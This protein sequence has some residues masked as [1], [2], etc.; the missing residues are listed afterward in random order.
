M[1]IVCAMAGA[2]L[3]VL[4]LRVSAQTITTEAPELATLI[5]SIFG[6]RGLTVHSDALLPDG[7]THSAHFNSAFQ[8]NFRQF[9]I[10]LASQLTSVP[11]P[12]PAS[13]FTYQFDQS[14][15]TFVRSTQS[16]GP[17]LA[18]RAETIGAGKILFGYN[19]Q[20]FSF[21]SLEGVSLRR[22][23][24]VFTHDDF[25]LGGGRADVV[26]T[27]NAIDASVSQFTG[28]VT[29]GLSD[30][31]DVS[32]A[33]PIVSTRL[34]VVSDAVIHRFGTEAGSAVHFFPEDT[35]P[36]GFGDTQQFLSQG[37]AAGVGDLVLRAKGTLVREGN[38]GFAAGLEIRVPSGD[39]HDLLGSGAWGAKPFAVMS[40]AVKKISPH[41]N[42]GYQWN[43]SSVLAGD[44]KNGIKED[45]PDRIT[46]AA[47]ADIGVNER[48]TLALDFL[49]DRIVG[50]PRLVTQPFAAAGPLGSGT[51]TDLTFVEGS[52]F[53][54]N[55]S[56]GIKVNVAP[57]MLV[58]FNVRFSTSK[59]GLTDRVAPLL[60][61]EYGF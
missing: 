28:L 26:V 43:G 4:P 49:A 5:Q 33:V 46:V 50:S 61:I 7:S 48:L 27:T 21:D 44:P 60:G 12:S 58:N 38:R 11:L 19:Y 39:E 22:I 51:F 10:A 15:G 8:S 30:R 53:L 42:I 29:Y 31:F 16:F 13:G 57:G 40:F 59:H 41:V 14:T 45:L 34:S 2:F 24:A 54:T 25:Q 32:V 55:G 17:I 18:D 52:Y 37:S 1:R 56:A 6:P 3:L 23:P 20:F 47:G 9:N 36:G 35:A